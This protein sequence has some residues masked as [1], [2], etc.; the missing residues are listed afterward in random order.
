MKIRTDRIKIGVCPRQSNP[1]LQVSHRHEDPTDTA[2]VQFVE[3]GYG[4]VIYQRHKESRRNKDNRPA[5]IRWRYT[6]Y[7]KRMLV[8]LDHAAHHAAIIVKASV[9]KRVAENDVWSTVW[10]MIVGIVKKAAQIRLNTK[11]IKVVAAR[12]YTPN[13]GGTFAC[14]QSNLS[15]AITGQTIKAVVAVAQIDIVGI[16]LARV[17]V[18]RALNQVEAL[19]IWNIQRPQN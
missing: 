5:K 10:P 19:R 7:G 13:Q 16:R 15:D 17:L 1:T 18:A 14:V 4:F 12:L 2:I 3:S 11:Y 8:Q 6:D 9:P